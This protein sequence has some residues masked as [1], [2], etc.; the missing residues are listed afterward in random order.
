LA[1]RVFEGIP[2]RRCAGPDEIAVRSGVT[3]LEVIRALPML[4][5]AGVVE[6][7]D[8]GYRVASRMRRPAR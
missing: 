8:G 2:G 7:G 5:L 4:D 3:A 1:R 6:A